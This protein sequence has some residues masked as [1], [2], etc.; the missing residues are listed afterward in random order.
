MPPVNL[1][2]WSG[3]LGQYDFAV[4]LDCAA[5]AGYQAMS[6]GPW[7]CRSPGGDGVESRGAAQSGQ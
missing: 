2:L 5:R 6:V 4:R 3:T 7:D 1:T